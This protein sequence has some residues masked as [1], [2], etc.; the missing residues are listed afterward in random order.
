[1]HQRQA[2]RRQYPRHA[3]QAKGTLD[4]WKDVRLLGLSAE[5]ARIHLKVLAQNRSFSISPSGN[6]HHVGDEGRYHRLV[7]IKVAGITVYTK[8]RDTTFS[9]EE[10]SPLITGFSKDWDQNV[11]SGSHNFMVLFIPVTVGYR[12]GGSARVELG[13]ALNV[14]APH[15][16]VYGE[17][18][19]FAYGEVWGGVGFT[20]L[21]ATINAEMQFMKIQAR[22]EFEIR[23]RYPEGRIAVERRTVDLFLKACG[24]LGWITECLTIFNYSKGSYSWERDLL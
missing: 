19:A 4:F 14:A 23:A 1:A 21:S 17:G 22:P 6:I 16:Y 9:G 11:L 7:R 5:A 8:E 13:A 20:Y 3:K 24:T 15:L 2:N 10:T 18:K 12:A